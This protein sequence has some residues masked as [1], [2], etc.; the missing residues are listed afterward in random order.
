M[1]ATTRGQFV[2]ILLLL[3]CLFGFTPTG[4]ASDPVDDFVNRYMHDHEIPG[5]AIM[6]RHNG[7]VVTKVYGK[8]NLEC[9]VPVTPQTLFQSASVGKQFTAM[10]VMLLVEDHKLSLDDPISKYLRVPPVPKNWSRI[11]V[12]H[13]LTHTSGLGDYPKWLTYRDDYDDDGLLNMV[14]QERLCYEPGER[15]DYSNLGYVTLG[16]LIRNRSGEFYGDFLQKR[17]FGPL[18]MKDTRVI[19]DQDIIP[20]RASGYFLDDNNNLKNQVWVSPTF[21]STADGTLYFTVEDLAKWDEALEA[22]KL[23]SHDSFKQIWTPFKLNDGSTGPYGFG[24]FIDHTKSGHRMLWHDGKWQ[25]FSAYIARY[26]GD[27]L[28]VATLCNRRSADNEDI[29][30][31]ITK[32]TAGIYVPALASPAR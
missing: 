7:K 32:Q 29:T 26:P 8:A 14:T 17:V 2:T 11:T 10:A 13:L 18:G 12:R 6:V 25:G 28:T 31:E 5:C 15:F 4:R 1:A 21:N 19:S 16:L 27:R 20:N 3:A 22:E 30:E 23:L 9:G 24:W